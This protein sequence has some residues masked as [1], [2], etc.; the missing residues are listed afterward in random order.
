MSS[1]S[2]YKIK[3]LLS[4]YDSNRRKFPWRADAGTVPNVYHVWISEIMLQQTRTSTVI[5]YFDKFIT[6]WPTLEDLAKAKRD[7]ILH[8]WSGLG[9]YAR[10]RNLHLCARTV[11]RD[12]GGVFPSEIDELLMLPGIGLYTASAIA[13]IAFDQ[14]TVVIDANVERI[15][16]RL[17]AVEKPIP[18]SK[19]EIKKLAA[20]LFIDQRPG[21]LAQ[22]LMDLGATVCIPKKPI[23]ANCPWSGSCEANQSGDPGRWPVPNPKSPKV[24]RFGFVFWV[25]H[26]NGSI[27]LQKR[28]D[29]GILGGMTEI[30]GSQWSTKPLLAS[31]IQKHAP[32]AS[33]NWSPVPTKVLHTFSHFD[34]ELS[35][36]MTSSTTQPEGT[37]WCPLANLSSQPFPSL[38]KKVLGI[39]NPITSYKIC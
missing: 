23:C 15:V 26:P 8:A 32:I 10:A 16:A 7:D 9:Y 24:K 18:Q 14:S 20:T 5:P 4:W 3:K 34:L 29:R 11:A 12:Y 30:L 27:L 36:Y 31:T 33:A 17:F 39:M 22:A 35:I 38:M 1:P 21:D 6:R 28:P 2:D 25:Q 37:F 13:A 19:V